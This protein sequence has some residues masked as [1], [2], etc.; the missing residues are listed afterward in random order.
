MSEQQRL[1][2]E[3]PPLQP[4]H[5]QPLLNE[6]LESFYDSRGDDRSFV[7]DGMVPGLRTAPPPRDRLYQEALD[8]QARYNNRI[9]SR[10]PDPLYPAGGFPPQ[11]RNVHNIPLNQAQYRGPSP[12]LHGNGQRL[13]PVGLAN[14]G[15][16]P[17]HE[18]TQLLSL[19]NHQGGALQ[20][21]GAAG[22]PQYNNLHGINGPVRGS[23]PGA[24]LGALPPH[25][26]NH[27]SHLDP[28]IVHHQ[29]PPPQQQQHQL[30]QQQQQLQQQQLLA[31]V[32]ST[33]SISIRGAA[34][35]YGHQQSVGPAHA[36]RQHQSH[37]VHHGQLPPHL[38]SQQGLPQVHPQQQHGVGLN[39]GRGQGDPALIA[40]LMGQQQ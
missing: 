39:N 26:N 19:Q 30:H 14:L 20:I 7:P 5:R 22:P 23:T 2:L 10:N 21:L 34:N 9:P 3:Q 15:G 36:I 29:Q 24:Q 16:R 12:L 8:D 13:P 11:S 1:M 31:M 40:L 28:R 6:H 37:Q 35:N 32:N 33:N 4:A 18:P 38:H 27:A 25:L 17:P